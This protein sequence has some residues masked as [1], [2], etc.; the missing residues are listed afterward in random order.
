VSR[1]D[2]SNRAF[3]IELAPGADP[4]RLLRQL[5][6]SGAVVERFELVHPSL[7]QIFLQRVGAANAAAIGMS[8]AEP[9]VAVRG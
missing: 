4:Q 8:G 6:E 2:D 1:V 3:E 5:V 9:E 7:H